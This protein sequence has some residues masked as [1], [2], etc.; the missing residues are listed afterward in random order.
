MIKWKMKGEVEEMSDNAMWTWLAGLVVVLILGSILL[1][2]R[3]MRL[4]EQNY[5]SA[6]YEQVT[7]PG[8]MGYHWQKAK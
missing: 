8:A 6:G 7:L 5:I 4:V 3:H 1:G 2:T